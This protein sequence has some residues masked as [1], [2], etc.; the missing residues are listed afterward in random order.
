MSGGE[1]G[2]EK[3]GPQRTHFCTTFVDVEDLPL[4]IDHF[5]VQ[6]TAR[7][8]QLGQLGP[9]T[10]HVWIV[11]HGWTQLADTFLLDFRKLHRS[12]TVIVAPEALN[13][14]YIQ[15]HSKVGT[16]WM[17]RHDRLHEI[18][19]YIFY[20][21]TLYERIFKQIDREQVKLHVLGFS[22]GVATAWRWLMQGKAA[23][24]TFTIWAG[25]IPEEFTPEGMERLAK[26]RL[27]G[28]VGTRDKYISAEQ[29]EVY[30]QSMRKLKSDLHYHT[31][32]GNH[33]LDDQVLLCLQADWDAM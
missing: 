6:K 20:L 7:T 31:F 16:T 33:R 18:A 22:Q 32:D 21:N 13:R 29:A 17:T 12:D 1:R 25:T 28:V 26:L 10:R 5:T 11:I 3:Q 30:M 15:D 24:D 4:E 8:A 14:F 23:P 2:V 19:D 27:E 9:E